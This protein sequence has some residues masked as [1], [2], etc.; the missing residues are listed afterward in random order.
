MKPVTRCSRQEAGSSGGRPLK[1]IELVLGEIPWK[2]SN[3]AGWSNQEFPVL[4]LV[5]LG[6]LAHDL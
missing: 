1:M 4:F 2:C 5:F 3:A 6:G